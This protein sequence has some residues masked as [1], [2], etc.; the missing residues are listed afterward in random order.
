MNCDDEM[1]A[2]VSAHVDGELTPD[3]QKRLEAHLAECEACRRELADMQALKQELDMIK[4]TEP[5]DKEF[6]RYWS[7]VYNRLERGV[8]WVLLSVGAIVLLCYGGFKLV[9][10]IIG[11]PA[12]RWWVKGGVLAAVFGAA[13][14]FVSLLRERLAVRKADKYSREVER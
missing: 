4:F 10:E 13:V 14:L 5:T 11:D 7:G 1:R 9:E 2:L 8:A 12:L 6:Q 3:Q